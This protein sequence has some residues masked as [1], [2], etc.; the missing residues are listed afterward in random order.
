MTKL[1]FNQIKGN[2]VNVLDV[3][4][5]ADGTKGATTGTNNAAAFKALIADQT[6]TNV[7]AD[8]GV[9][10]FGPLGIDE[11]LATRTTNPIN[12]DWGGAYL[13]VNGDNATTTNT[14]MAFLSFDDVN[15]SMSNYTFEDTTF[16]V[17]TSVGRGAMPFAIANTSANTFGYN[18]GP[19]HIVKGQS[20]VTA[21]ATDP[22]NFRAE[23]INLVGS[24]TGE[25]MYYGVNLANNGDGFSGHYSMDTC[26]RALFVYGVKDCNA[27]FHCKTGQPSSSNLLVSNSGSTKPRTENIKVRAHFDLMDGPFGIA[28]QAQIAD[29]GDGRY[30][31][32]DVTLIVDSIGANLAINNPIVNIGAFTTS[33]TPT[34]VASGAVDADEIK[35][36]I[37]TPLAFTTPLVVQTASSNYGSIQLDGKFTNK[38]Q[39]DSFHLLKDRTVSKALVGDTT[40]STLS[41]NSKYLLVDEDGPSTV[42]WKLDVMAQQDSQF[43]TGKVSMASFDVIG[44]VSAG[45]LVVQQATE[46]TKTTQSTPIPTFV[47][48]ANGLNLDISVTGYASDVNGS[49]SA[50]L[51]SI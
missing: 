44:Y 2:S 26:N 14:S 24:C 11:V 27:N 41:L 17:A 10:Y 30:R 20:F 39:V 9:F 32:I 5:V 40:T 12:I 34:F 48:V 22:N 31:N 49:L 29:P 36:D 23:G 8:G 42:R 46:L 16:D 37:Q 18:I 28:D 45:V 7:V 19:C 50:V 43:S 35:I 47:V 4:L 15:G 6:V 25:N 33:G 3:G 38:T 51:R 1:A 21:G 13:I